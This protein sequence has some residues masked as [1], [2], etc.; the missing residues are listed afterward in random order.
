[1]E[2]GKYKLGPA[3]PGQWLLELYVQNRGQP[4]YTA[5]VT[6]A[7]GDNTHDIN[8]NTGAT[9]VLTVLHENRATPCRAPAATA[10]RAV[11]TAAAPMR[12]A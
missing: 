4:L 11:P 7:E 5:H 12:P 9:L 2:D 10:R 8:V 1:M 3:E 6:L